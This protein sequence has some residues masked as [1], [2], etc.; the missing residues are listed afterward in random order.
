LQPDERRA[1]TQSGAHYNPAITFTF[2]RLGKVAPQD[3]LYYTLAQFLGGTIGVQI[4]VWLAR[5]YH[6]AHQLTPA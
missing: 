2:R 3:T 4:A 1:A 5:A 6:R